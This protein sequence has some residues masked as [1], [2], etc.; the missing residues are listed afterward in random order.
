MNKDSHYTLICY[1]V[2]LERKCIHL[3]LCSDS[4][5][6]SLSLLFEGIILTRSPVGVYKQGR[7][8]IFF[9]LKSSSLS[10]ANAVNCTQSRII[11]FFLIVTVSEFFFSLFLWG[12]SKEK[13]SSISRNSL[14]F[15]F[16]K[17]RTFSF[18]REYNFI[19]I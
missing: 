4:V 18:Y 14:L 17:Q 13:I 12:C 6:L 11:V 19:L 8:I 1:P 10:P 3:F 15:F 2:F 5:F 9:L 16:S 7:K